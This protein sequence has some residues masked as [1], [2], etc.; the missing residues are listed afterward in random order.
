MRRSITALVSLF[1]LS[2]AGCYPLPSRTYSVSRYGVRANLVD[3]TGG[4]PIV[5]QPVRI[6]IDGEAFDQVTGSRGNVSIAPDRYAYWTWLGGPGHW[7]ATDAKIAINLPGYRP[8]EIDWHSFS[9]T[10]PYRERASVVDLG[11]V[12]LKER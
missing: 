7:H 3:E 12:T 5:K 10:Q 2:L 1:A 4:T 9:D 6:T 8:C 11:T